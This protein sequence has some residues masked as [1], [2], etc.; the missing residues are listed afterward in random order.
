MQGRHKNM[1]VVSSVL[2]IWHHNCDV[3]IYS[4]GLDVYADYFSKTC[5]I[6]FAEIVQSSLKVKLY[7]MVLK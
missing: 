3:G 2:S 7:E 6:L 1:I 4:Q 5:T